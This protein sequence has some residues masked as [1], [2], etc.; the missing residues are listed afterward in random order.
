MVREQ[1][2]AVSHHSKKMPT[3]AFR[4][5]VVEHIAAT[6]FALIGGRNLRTRFFLQHPRLRPARYRAFR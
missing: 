5:I 3:D 2:E 6:R 4:Y 1:L